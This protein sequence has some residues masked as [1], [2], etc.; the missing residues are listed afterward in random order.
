MVFSLFAIYRCNLVAANIIPSVFFHF[1]KIFQAARQQNRKIVEDLPKS[2][3]PFAFLKRTDIFLWKNNGFSHFF[4]LHM[5][6]GR[7]LHNPQCFFSFSK[8][9]QGEGNLRYT[10]ILCTCNLVATYRIPSVCHLFQIFHPEAN[11]RYTTI[12]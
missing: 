3:N 7:C 1:Q 12:L 6:F 5:Q 10:T 9:N 11:L 4:N 2:Q 8:K